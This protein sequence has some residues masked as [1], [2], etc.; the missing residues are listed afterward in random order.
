MQ[1]LVVARHTITRNPTGRFRTT[2]ETNKKTS[3][4]I[5]RPISQ[6]ISPGEHFTV[7]DEAEYL[8]L[9]ENGAIWDAIEPAPTEH[10][11]DIAEADD[12]REVE[13]GDLIG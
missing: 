7:E 11:T 12:A 9:M 6:R 1:K 4:L 13:P 10:A 8:T 3:Q 2:G 5:R